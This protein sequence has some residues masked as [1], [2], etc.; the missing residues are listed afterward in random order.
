MPKRQGKVI[1]QNRKASHDYFIEDTY[2]AGMVL[3]GTE[4]KSIRAGRV[5][6]KDSHARIDHGEVKL[7]NLHI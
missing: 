6:I 5:S 2:E 3:Q 4:I 1:A 7:I